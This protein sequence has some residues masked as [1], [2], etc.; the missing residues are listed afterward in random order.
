MNVAEIKADDWFKQ[1]YAPV[2]PKDDD[3]DGDDSYGDSL[4]VKEVKQ[5]LFWRG[6]DCFESELM[7]WMSAAKCV[8]REWSFTYTYQCVPADRNVFIARSFWLLRE[9]GRK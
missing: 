4:P 1:D 6:F 7:F 5:G 2:F 9:R 8:R 3:D